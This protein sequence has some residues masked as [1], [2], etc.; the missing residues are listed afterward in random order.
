VSA[1]HLLAGVLAADYARVPRGL[2]LAGVDID[3]LRRRL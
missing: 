3:E 1:H 2:P